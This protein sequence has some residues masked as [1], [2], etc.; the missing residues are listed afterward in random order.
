MQ[1]AAGF[2]LLEL[3]LLFLT[4]TCLLRTSCWLRADSILTSVTLLR[5]RMRF[6]WS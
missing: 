5:L 2:G 3:P 4:P 1:L 6:A